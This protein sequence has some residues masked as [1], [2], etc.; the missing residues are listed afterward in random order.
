MAEA[1][2]A[3]GKA[4]VPEA[5]PR[6]LFQ[7]LRSRLSGRPDTEDKQALVRLMVG[8]VLFV[9]LLP[10]ALTDVSSA[11]HGVDE[12]FLSAMVVHL[13]VSTAIF[14]WIVAQ[15]GVSHV[16]R[17]LGALLDTASVTFFM[18]QTG[19]YGAPLFLVF[20][21]YTQANGVRYGPRYLWVSLALNIVG[22]SIVLAITPFWQQYLGPGI[23]MMVGMVAL[24][25]YVL[26]LVKSL[27]DALNRAESA[28]LAKRRFISV[29]SHE[30]RTPLNAVIGMT[31]LLRDS[32]LN[33][34]Q[35]EMVSTMGSAGRVLLGL[36]EDVLDFSKIEAG[37][38]SIETIDFD[39]HALVNATCRILQP[40]AETKGLELLVSIMPE[41]PPALRGDPHHI[42]QIL[43]NLVG[44]A[45]KFTER[46]SITV[47]VSLLAETD[48]AVRAKFSVRDTG[49]GI[50]PEAQG[51][52]FESFV[53]EDQT[54]T[55]RF[56]GTGLGTTIAKQLV[57]LMGGRMG[58]E[59]AVG[60]GSTF[61]FEVEL[62][63][64]PESASRLFEGEAN[65]SRVLAVGFGSEDREFL[66]QT[67]KGWGVSG[68]FVPN[69]VE[70]G[71]RI[72]SDA[73]LAKPFRSVLVLA[74]TL[75]D[76]KRSLSALRRGTGATSASALPIVL[77]TQAS[78]AEGAAQRLAAISAG[79]SAA[80]ELPIQK[81]LLFNVLHSVTAVED[82][83]AS[84]GVVQLRDYLK[85]RE[86]G[87]RR[88]RVV[89]ADDSATNRQVLGKILERGGHTVT[90]VDD[91]E[92]ALDALETAEYDI[93]ILDRNMPGMGGVE[94][95]RALRAMGHRRDQFPVIIL[96]A[97]VTGDTRMECDEAGANAFL[98]KP[99]EAARL[100]D[101]VAEL[102]G[103][104]AEVLA[105]D[106]ERPSARPAGSF[107]Q[108]PGGL[109]GP[110]NLG[111]LQLL[112]GLG[113]ASGFLDRLIGVFINDNRLILEKME[114][115]VSV[116]DFAEFR[117]QLHAMKGSAAS[118]GA[119]Q[120]A[121][122]CSATN[123]LTDSEM[124]IQQRHLAG[125]IKT[126]F[127]RAEAA[128]QRYLEDRHRT[129]G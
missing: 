111:T 72:A 112:E 86:G 96:S 60:L 93:A 73:G 128:L 3:L 98:P 25:L 115:S 108:A 63:K 47:H 69:A 90:L 36:I 88:Y 45:V 9:Y 107:S 75:E 17:V 29:V 79:F 122:A 68:V 6:G 123:G 55:R 21:W 101:A 54:T 94:T 104:A 43:I 65:D 100:L 41:V 11:Q 74:S 89:V 26:S 52:I 124:G 53:Q 32:Q 126:E 31:E 1:D 84:G 10:K 34:E 23:G 49:I 12:L 97:D 20:I 67:M 30:M 110:L 51:R 24:A 71:Q 62:P 125:S 105:K 87:S 109:A 95:L 4:A 57:E 28:N 83:T 59:S 2:Q 33:R 40:Q 77:C 13:V 121:M 35:S 113:T 92:F 127:E 106:R 80:L 27:S 117:R 76:A 81:R 15:P 8:C 66:Q 70:G 82:G 48:A 37:K 102:C 116:R 58:L 42:R 118:I 14:G 22:F 16:R 91:G 56:G 61:W 103:S 114:R 85:K 120:L 5:P 64:Q 44:N 38:L 119:E 39:L 18:S 78:G 50:T 46:G 7:R 99:V 19:A 129:T